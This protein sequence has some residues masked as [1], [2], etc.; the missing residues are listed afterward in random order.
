M[1]N[2]VMEDAVPVKVAAVILPWLQCPLQFPEC[3]C[4]DQAIVAVSHKVDALCCARGCN[5]NEGGCSD[6]AEVALHLKCR[7]SFM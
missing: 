2:V 1:Q 4:R 6:P 3:G 5:Y 7:F